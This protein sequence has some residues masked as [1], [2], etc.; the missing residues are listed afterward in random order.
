MSKK[1]RG[2]GRGRGGPGQGG[3]GQ[4][5]Y[6]G[7][8]HPRGRHR[9]PRP[10]GGGGDRP[11]GGQNEPMDIPDNGEPIATEPASGVL[12]LHPNGY[13]FLR[14]TK[15]NYQRERTDPFVPGTMIEKFGRREG[16]LING[17]VQQNRRQEGPRLKEIIDV[18]GLKPEEYLL[19]KNFDALTPINP[20]SWLEL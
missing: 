19:V 15:T 4:G 8:G 13:G 9:R 5:H 16:V 7:N 14:D 6:Q 18:D 3:P 10:H 11:P 2:R 1:K 17:L 12:E 20:E